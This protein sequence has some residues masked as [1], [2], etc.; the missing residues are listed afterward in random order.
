MQI[1]LLI[2]TDYYWQFAGDCNVRGEG[3]IAMQ[4]YLFSRLLTLQIPSLVDASVLHVSIPTEVHPFGWLNGTHKPTDTSDPNLIDHYKQS[5]IRS[6]DNST[7]Y[8]V[9]SFCGY[10]NTHPIPSSYTEWIKLA[11]WLSNSAKIQSSYNPAVKSLWNKS[12]EASSRRWPIQ[13]TLQMMFTTYH[14]KTSSTGLFTIVVSI[15]QE[16]PAVF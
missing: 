1:S 16:T 3:S 4:G 5:Y 10:K 8:T 6:Q 14:R 2:G 7:I 11:H 12:K 9:S 15:D 13:I